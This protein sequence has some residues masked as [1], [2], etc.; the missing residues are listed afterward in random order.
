M[1]TATDPWL[2][3]GLAQLAEPDPTA[4]YTPEHH[5]AECQQHLSGTAQIVC[6]C[7]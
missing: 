1:S 6:V 7:R 5:T 3:E 4:G 2:C